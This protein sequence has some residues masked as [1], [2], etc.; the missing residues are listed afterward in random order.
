MKKLFAMSGWL[1]IFGHMKYE[2]LHC[3][4]NGCWV[5]LLITVKG[6]FW[7]YEVYCDDRNTVI[8]SR[9]HSGDYHCYGFQR[10]FL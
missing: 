6:T 7:E 2:S 3:S 9:V 8:M 1:L 5:A 10:K 4:L